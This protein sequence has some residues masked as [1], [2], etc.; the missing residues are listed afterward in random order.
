MISRTILITGATGLIGRHLVKKLSAR[1][2]KVIALSTKGA[3]AGKILPEAYK[4]VGWD[5]YLSL[6]NEK[7]YGIINLAGMNLA[8]KRWNWTV[9]KQMYDSRIVNTATLV[10]LIHKMETKPDVLVSASGVDFYGDTGDKNIYEDSPPGNG[11]ASRL[12]VDWEKYAMN[13]E[14]YGVRV[15]TLRTGVVI[16]H[17]SPGIKKMLLP[18]KLFVGGAPGSGKQYMSW[19]HIDDITDIYL[20]ALENKNMKGVFNAA[21]PNPVTMN[22]FCRT[23][24][25]LIHRPSFMPVPAFA[26]KILF[27]EVSELLLSGRKA[28]PDKLMKLGYKFQFTNLKEALAASL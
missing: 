18:F 13:A 4:S 25:G 1:G 3:A 7:I 21:A 10:H 27:G 28:L 19:I 9:K 8:G 14:E 23:L 17:D 11:Y 12:C 5:D 2:D 16:A 26:L 24:G 15:V 6:S 20:F 22:E